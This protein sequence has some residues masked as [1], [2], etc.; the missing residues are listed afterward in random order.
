MRA[1]NGPGSLLLAALLALGP[2]GGGCASTGDD[3]IDGG[4]DTPDDVEVGADADADADADPDVGDDAGADA[5]A[6]ADDDG[7]TDADADVETGVC[8]DGVCNAP[9]ED[10]LTCAT[11]CPAVC[12]DGVC[13]HDESPTAC[14]TDCPANCGDGVCTH[15]EDAASCARDCPAV[16]GDGACTHDES[17]ATCATDCPGSC[18]DGACTAGEHAGNC[19]TDCP[20]SC[21]D[22]FCTH[23]EDAADCPDD[24]PA[25][26]GDGACTHTETAAT[27]PAD[28]PAVCGDTFCTH[29][30][31]IAT[32]PADCPVRCG[33][34][35]CSPGETN[36][37]CPAD[38]TL[39]CGNGVLETGEEC[40]DGNT[41]RCDGC[42][43]TCTVELAYPRGA[44][45]VSDS[46]VDAAA[47]GT[48]LTAEGFTHAARDNGTSGVVTAD[49]D[50]LLRHAVVVFHNY[51]R[52][53]A[54]AEQTALD[55]YVQCGGVLL[56]TGYDSL[57]SP[58]DPLLA[59]VA[60]VGTSGDGPFS[61]ACTVATDAN[62]ALDGP[63]GHFA[64]ATAF[65]VAQTDHDAVTADATL[66]SIELL[67]VAGTNA[68]L[69]YAGDVGANHGQ[70]YFWNGNY[71]YDDWTTAGIAQDVFL[72]LLNH[73]LRGVL[74]LADSGTPGTAVATLLR[75]ECYDTTS[76][77]N[78]TG[79]LSG[80]FW[81]LRRYPYVVYYQSNRAISAA[82]QTALDRYVRAGGMLLVTGYDSLGSPTDPLLAAVVH[83]TTAGDGPFSSA[84]AVTD[85]THPAMA[86]PYGTFAAGTAFTVTQTDHD[87]AAA[88]ASL[89]SV[90]LASVDTAA[91]LTWA[92]GIGFQG[93]AYYWNGNSG[94]A[95]W[96]SDS[97]ARRIFLNLVDHEVG[98]GSCR[99]GADFYAL[100]YDFFEFDVAAANLL[101]RAV[102]FGFARTPVVGAV[103]ECVDAVG[104]TSAGNPGGPYLG[105]YNATL[106]ALRLAGL[107]AA[108]V[109]P[110]ADAA[111]A[112]TRAG[113]YDVLLFMEAETCV[114]TAASW[115]APVAALIATGGRVVV[116]YPG[117]NASFV[118][119]L[120]LFGTGTTS[121]ATTPYAAVADRFWEGGLVHPGYLN[122][123]QAWNWS[124]TG[125][126][127]LGRDAGGTNLTVWGYE[128]D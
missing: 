43:P 13:T 94:F 77:D 87:Q 68:K 51:N 92:D 75:R 70:V 66:G 32:C 69:T 97:T 126:V 103:Q 45:L 34:G 113:Q 42:S 41:T 3:T 56:V 26:C 125:L 81:R 33:D 65:T 4:T 122:A 47:L 121:S 60:R 100:P 105:E 112:A 72:N 59:A 63:Y 9:G 29:T 67:R 108:N 21:G 8:G 54:A 82:E 11:D 19:P 25:S 80:D 84:C 28:C 91:K 46:G 24:C 119:G 95:D 40:D 76:L 38:C 83:V 7:G 2:L 50:A 99:R 86:G 111:D 18:G 127:P 90:Q 110:L 53:I 35:V 79:T 22:T 118:S 116:T 88:D 36:A 15:D 85:G 37:T 1:S 57:G 61:T 101:Y 114:P 62:P 71:G 39:A 52:A 73:H 98:R 27:C 23:D 89:G 124:G 55:Q 120:G 107:P 31:T 74:L 117:N 17:S 5:D 44:L 102:T 109:L 104:S 48:L 96:S 6:D 30:E 106:G 14:E 58:T 128:V 20:A 123:T 78:G 16:C 93:T 115:T 12:G 64:P 10:A 49:V